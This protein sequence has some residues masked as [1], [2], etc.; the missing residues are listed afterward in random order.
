MLGGLVLIAAVLAIVFLLLRGVV[1]AMSRRSVSTG[2]FISAAIVAGA[3][4]MALLTFSLTSRDRTIELGQPKCFDDWCVTVTRADHDDTGA[5]VEVKVKSQARRAHMRPDHPRIEVLDLRGRVFTPLSADGPP[6][7]KQLAPGEEFTASFQFKVA[8]DLL[9]PV[10]L[11][12][13]GGWLTR[14][15]IGDENSFCHRKIVT[16]LE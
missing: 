11:V 1:S 8:G 3:Y 7:N 16:P 2:S 14:L 4:A 10:V 6:L 15:I 9:H 5:V 12:S 13:E